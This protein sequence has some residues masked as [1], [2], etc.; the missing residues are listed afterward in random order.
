MFGYV[1]ADM[2]RLSKESGAE[3]KAVYCSLCKALK[4]K[5]GITARYILNYDVTFLALVRLSQ[6]QGEPESYEQYCPYKMKKCLMIRDE[7]EI[8]YECASALI[9]LAYHKIC[10]NIKDEGFFKSFAYRFLR[11]HYGFKYRKA[12][13]HLPQVA[14]MIEKNMR[15][16]SEYE[17]ERNAS[18]D[19]LAHPSAD[20]LG[21]LF[22][23]NCAEESKESLYRFGYCMG[24]WIYITDAADD[25]A[26]DEKRG[27]FNPFGAD[28]TKERAEALMNVSVAEAIEAYENVTKYRY[29]KI[30]D[31]ILYDGTEKIQKSVLK[32]EGEES[33]SV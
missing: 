10:D 29:I 2:S 32:A 30:L 17:K 33:E 11:F 13:K 26:D 19:K 20:G 12:K 7:E 23:I 8:F 21:N 6:Q 4:T 1:K 9:M 24:R 22:C 31:N 5:Y 18:L 28:F 15:L 27:R 25:Y 16:Q 14:E 3:Y